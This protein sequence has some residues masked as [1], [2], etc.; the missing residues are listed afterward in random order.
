MRLLFWLSLVGAVYSYFLYPLVLLLLPGRKPVKT[1]G[2]IRPTVSI[3]VTAHNEAK[4]IEEK[5]RN[6]LAL[7]YPREKL[8]IIVAS[9]SST[10]DTDNIAR[11]FEAQAVRLVRAEE[12]KGKE[13]AQGLAVKA[14][15]GDV[16]VFSDVAT[17]I[18]GGAIRRLVECFEDPEVGA[19]S[20]EDRFLSESGQIV[21]EGVY[22][23][24]E[25]W[26]RR[27]ESSVHSLVGLSGSFFAA[28]NS[29]C[30]D[31]RIDVPSDF[32]TALNCV[33][34]HR[35]AVSDREVV[36]IY[37]NIADSSGEYQRKFRTVIRGISAVS[38]RPD[39]LNPFKFGFFAFQVFSH[40]VMR[41]LVP[42]FLILLLTANIF[43]LHQHWIYQAALV[44][45]LVFYGLALLGFFAPITR[46]AAI[47][48]LPF[49]FTQANTAIL[50]AMVAFAIGKR[51]TVW[52]PSKR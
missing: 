36:G 40:K 33:R 27:L 4:R 39:V 34:Q 11:Q 2:G 50:H 35:I 48:K 52:N 25:M 19:V 10:D 3:I 30:E 24:Y 44:A 17:S 41:W 28:R 13:Y 42:W 49:F 45:Q 43:L 23:K 21:G 8:D 37:K 6:T 9:D 12:R 38:A 46:A 31:W 29:V 14:A 32:N 51:V 47:V 15:R 22:V 7:D 26:L 20:S 16:L 5:L 1:G 18:P